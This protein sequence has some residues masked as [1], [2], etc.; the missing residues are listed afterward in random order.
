MLLHSKMRFIDYR[1]EKVRMNKSTLAIAAANQHMQEREYWLNKLSGELNKS[2]FPYDYSLNVEENHITGYFQFKLNQEVYSKVMKLSNGAP[3]SIFMILATNLVLLLDQ[4]MNHQDIVIGTTILKQ[5]ENKDFINTVLAL[6]NAVQNEMSFRQL[7]L[8]VRKSFVE[9]VENQNYPLETLIYQ[10]GLEETGGINPLFDVAIVL[11]NIQEP[12]YL[13]KVKTSMTMCF[14][15]TEESI[16]CEVSY[17]K[18]YYSEATVEKIMMQF[19]VILEQILSNYDIPVK[20]IDIVS[21]QEKEILVNQFNKSQKAYDTHQTIHSL[22]EAQAQQT[23]DNIAVQF[24]DQTMTY[25][26]LDKKVNELASLLRNKGVGTDIAHNMVGIMMNRSFELVIGVLAILKAGGAYIPI[27][28]EYP[29]ERKQYMLQDSQ[30]KLLL[31]NSQVEM[32]CTFDGEVITYDHQEDL[33]QDEIED[34]SNQL[35]YVIYTSG[36]TGQPK[37][38]LIEH[39]SIVNT[40]L[41][42]KEFYQFTGQ[43]VVLQIPS[44]SFDS[45]VED[46]FTAL[47]SGAKLLLINAQDRLNMRYLTTLITKEKVTNFLITPALYKALI[48]QPIEYKYLRIIT[49]AGDS[50]SK[51]LVEKHFE[52]CPNVRLINEYGPT[53]NSVCSTA[54]EFVASDIKLLI[55]KPISNVKCYVVNKYNHLSAIGMSGELCVAGAGL[56]KGYLNKEALTSEKFIVNPFDKDSNRL[57]KTGDLV[58]WI[59]DG[60][61]EFIGR[62]DE[63][64]KIRGF[65]IELGEIEKQL[66]SLNDIKET[67]VLVQKDKDDT[68]FLVQYYTSDRKVSSGEIRAYL[69]EHMPDYMIPSYFVQ[70][71]AMPLTPNG[72]INRKALLECNCYVGDHVEYEAP[73]SEVELQLTKMWQDILALEKIGI[74]DNFFEIGGHSLKATSL[75]AQ[76]QREMG[77]DVPMGQ[78]FKTA[79]IKELALYIESKKGSNESNYFEIECVEEADYYPASLA[80]QRMYLVNEI[81]GIKT[82]Y[83][84]PLIILVD[85]KIDYEKAC[86]SLKEVI[87]RHDALRTSFE[88]IDQR[89]V[90]RVYKDVTFNVMYE[91][92]EED[93]LEECA[94]SFVQNFD[95]KKAP[96]LRCKFIALTSGKTALLFDMHHIISD[97]VS[98]SILVEE[99]VQLYEGKTLENVKIQYRDF[100]AWQEKN[101]ETPV[102]MKQKEYWL[103]QLAGELAP[104]NMV[105]DYPRPAIQSYK[106]NKIRRTI[107]AQVTRELKNIASQCHSTIFNVL[108]SAYNV[109][110]SKYTGQEEII[111]G[112]PVAGR[113]HSQLEDVMGMFINMLALRNYVKHDLT[114]AQFLNEV[115]KTSIDAFE[116]QDYPFNEV[117]DA[118][119]LP[120]DISCSPVFNIMFALENVD[121]LYNE[122]NHIPFNIVDVQT[123][124]SKYDMTIIAREINNEIEIAIE[125][126]TDLYKAE[127]MERFISHFETLLS[128][129]YENVNKKIAEI[130]IAD[131]EDKHKVL[132]EFKGITKA[133]EAQ[134]NVVQLFKAQV[135]SMP[136]HIAL[137]EEDRK[138]TYAEVDERTTCIAS[139]LKKHIKQT[140]TIV[141]VMIDNSIDF[142]IGILGVLKAGLAYLPIDPEYPNA[143]IKY[144]LEDSKVN[145][146]LIGAEDVVDKCQGVSYINMHDQAIY[147]AVDL[148]MEVAIKDDDLAYVI[149]TSG[150]TGEPKGVMIAHNALVN[151]CMWHKQYYEITPED[152]VAKYASV[153]FDASVW[154]IFPTLISGATL[155][156]PPKAIKLD[157]VKLNHYFEE[158]K[159]SITFLPTQIAEQFMEL[160]N[161]SLRI[162]LTGGDKLTQFNKKPYKL[163]NNYGPTENTVVTTSYLVN[164]AHTN[165]PIGKPIYNTALYILDDAHHLQPIGVPGEIYIS[166]KS[167]ARG[168]LHREA[169]TQKAF[170]PSPFNENEYMYKTGDMGRWLP[171]GIVEFLGRR[172]QQVKIRGNRIEL[173]EIEN[174]L[175]HFDA[176]QEVVVTIKGKNKYLCAYVVMKDGVALDVK[177]IK[178]YLKE[179][180]PQY[181]IPTHFVSVENIPVTPNGKIDFKQLPEVSEGLST[182]TPYLAPQNKVEE[183]ILAIWQSVLEVNKIGVNDNFFDIGGNS[184]LVMK[185]VQKIQQELNVTEDQVA[186]MT[187][188]KYPTIAL[189][190]QQIEGNVEEHSFNQILER[191]NKRLQS[192]RGKLARRKSDD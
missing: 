166:G 78:L 183:K 11:K 18:A 181:M 122:I 155:Y 156:M 74:N 145:T 123:D 127:T 53:E 184:L 148:D 143:R 40:L 130:E 129:L 97:G 30:T 191:T 125:Y 189:M 37:G 71:D 134:T 75:I 35:A 5:E 154:E 6:R 54:Y 168:Y 62:V 161:N 65:R 158:N 32:T 150:S 165:I 48:E 132:N 72:K 185:V 120:R 116:N 49:I 174:V 42:R 128:G 124:T 67:I 106:G 86:S 169:L 79:T 107:N 146:V 8:Q 13:D 33:P 175:N 121:I 91:E 167:L 171:E 172:D 139:Y 100:T 58:R 52:K 76:I 61:I 192:R 80:Q 43:D 56:A 147:E 110:L 21:K 64:V 81:E 163:F 22:F 138:Y 157:C 82:T 29:Q 140:D 93:A 41:W 77:V 38:V 173:G 31:I 136:D 59:A 1:G 36:S 149:Y 20:D 50:F 26:E 89:L 186:V 73:T 111:I 2:Y 12:K 19:S 109:L 46:I 119:E 34:L 45:S 182:I 108:L 180:L 16:E 170:I 117:V 51:E 15:K 27:D 113:T 66:L 96:L 112:S 187:M 152:K 3:A 4:H 98:M 88:F 7:L 102:M 90:Q 164:E 57:Y 142:V 92:M 23:P 137:V 190:A 159:I 141:A 115:T 177:V 25:K 133:I 126:C 47:I 114:F 87:Q 144:M 118:L 63:Q 176:I 68:K 84:V 28:P 188:F 85:G 178:E 24:N 105:T 95:F 69:S 10:L 60:D 179:R 44:F 162:L 99:F 14:E 131:E 39:H 101:K 17:C 153:A 104:L 83:N 103:K 70:V 94:K 9:A 160:N 135:L 55:G 151:L